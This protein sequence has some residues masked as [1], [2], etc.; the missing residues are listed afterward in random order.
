MKVTSKSRKFSSLKKLLWMKISRYTAVAV[1]IVQY[2]CSYNLTFMSMNLPAPFLSSQTDHCQRSPFCQKG[3]ER[4]FSGSCSLVS[5][6]SPT[7]A[8]TGGKSPSP[9]LSEGREVKEFSIINKIIFKSIVAGTTPLITS[10]N[11]T[12]CKSV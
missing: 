8:R 7:Y 5:Q 4:A 1:V 3:P 6:R 12:V 10:S 2:T 11:V 9:L